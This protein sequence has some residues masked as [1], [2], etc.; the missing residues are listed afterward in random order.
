MVLLSDK[1]Q[2]LLYR[3]SITSQL[4]LF[5]ETVYSSELYTPP[6]TPCCVT[7]T[8]PAPSMHEPHQDIPLLW[9][10][11]SARPFSSSWRDKYG[12]SVNMVNSQSVTLAAV[13]R[14]IQATTGGQGGRSEAREANLHACP[15][16][17]N[18]SRERQVTPKCHLG[19]EA[20]ADWDNV[21]VTNPLATPW[22]S[23]S[24]LLSLSFLI[25]SV[26]GA[27]N[28]PSNSPWHCHLH[29]L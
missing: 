27:I 20:W 24:Y 4:S 23:H 6:P 8:D 14:W 7:W 10:S 26:Y 1:S 3:P 22:A 16:A 21:P 5:Q 11:V 28:I 12:R 2:R 17:A 18:W 29:L 25:R 9:F 15:A 13:G 19:H